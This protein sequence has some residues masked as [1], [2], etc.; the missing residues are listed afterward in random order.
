MYNLAVILF[1]FAEISKCALLYFIQRGSKS[2]QK[3]YYIQVVL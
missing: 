3:Q 2:K 1:G